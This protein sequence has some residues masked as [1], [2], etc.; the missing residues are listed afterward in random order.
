MPPVITVFSAPN[1]CCRYGNKGAVL[2]IKPNPPAKSRFRKAKTSGFKP[3]ELLEPVQFSEVAAPEPMQFT[4]AQENL[5]AQISDSC[6]YMPTTFHSFIHKASELARVTYEMELEIQ[7]Q[8]EE[9]ESQKKKLR[10]S[11]N[12]DSLD[13]SFLEGDL[14][15]LHLGEATLPSGPAYHPPEER[16]AQRH[17]DSAAVADGINEMN[18]MLLQQKAEK[19]KAK[20]SELKTEVSSENTVFVAKDG[21]TTLTTSKEA[22][23]ALRKTLAEKKK[24]KQ[25]TTI[26]EGKANKKASF[27]NEEGDETIINFTNQELLSL[28][29]LFLLIDRNDKGFFDQD[30]LVLWSQQEGV[31]VQKSEAMLCIKA[32]DSD[33]DGKIG[34]EDYLAFAARSKDRWLVAQYKEVA[35]AVK[36][37]RV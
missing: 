5:E 18:P 24:K 33:K 17:F 9:E 32:V 27:T 19:A 37:S 3:I 25:Q 29:L 36:K 15:Q 28:Q 6:P 23:K 16:D 30:D 31:P 12:L 10:A 7:K 22:G 4:S 11:A 21:R 2:K 1:Y 14:S 34:F 26:V 8:L 35:Q 20:M 13:L